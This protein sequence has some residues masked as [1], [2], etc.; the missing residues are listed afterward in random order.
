MLN[1]LFTNPTEEVIAESTKTKTIDFV[2]SNIG[3]WI[4]EEK[5]FN[6]GTFQ[7]AESYFSDILSGNPSLSVGL[8]VYFQYWH[9]KIFVTLSS[10]KASIAVENANKLARLFECMIGEFL[11]PFEICRCTHEMFGPPSSE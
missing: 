9:G 3:K 10:N 7:I 8:G 1:E 4:D 5:R 6:D 11:S 2:V